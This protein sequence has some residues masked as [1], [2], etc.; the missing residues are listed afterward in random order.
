M[1]MNR[2]RVDD[3]QQLFHAAGHRVLTNEADRDESVLKQL[4][5]GALRLDQQFASKSA[6][7]LA[8]TASWVI[9]QPAPRAAERRPVKIPA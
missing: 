9:S 2:L 4:R 3:I 7:V 5:A 8:A 6:E 1:Y